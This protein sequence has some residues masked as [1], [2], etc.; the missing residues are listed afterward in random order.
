VEMCFLWSQAFKRWKGLRQISVF[1]GLLIPI[2]HANKLVWQQF[3]SLLAII[4][5]ELVSKNL[6]GLWNSLLLPWFHCGNLYAKLIQNS[7]NQKKSDIELALWHH[8]KW[9]KPICSSVNRCQILQSM[10]TKI[11]NPI[12]S[13]G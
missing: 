8:F 4:R 9:I 11:Q 6:F 2:Q 7:K 5:S 1:F 13:N 10:G 3:I 12:E